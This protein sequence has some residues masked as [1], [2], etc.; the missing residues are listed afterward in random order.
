MGQRACED[1]RR[2]LPGSGSIWLE[3]RVEP[4]K[5]TVNNDAQRS[6]AGSGLNRL[7]PLSNNFLHA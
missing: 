5:S 2:G 6:I 4:R 1:K 7:I 3:R